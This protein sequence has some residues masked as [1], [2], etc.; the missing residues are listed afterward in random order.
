[1]FRDKTFHEVFSLQGIFEEPRVV[2]EQKRLK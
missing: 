2:N 1:M